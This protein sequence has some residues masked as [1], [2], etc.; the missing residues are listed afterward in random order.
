MARP[1]AGVMFVARTHGVV[2]LV[3]LVSILLL[4]LLTRNLPGIEFGPRTYQYAGT[5]AGIYFLVA[6][7]VWLGAPLGPLLSR[8]CSLLYL[9]RPSFGLRVWETMDSPEFRAHFRRGV[10]PKEKPPESEAESE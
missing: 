9:L 5:L 3:I 6:V 2:C 4:H 1:P 10:S 8:V 7:L